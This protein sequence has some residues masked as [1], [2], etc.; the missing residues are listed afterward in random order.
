MLNVYS[1]S[2]T[3]NGSTSS[4]YG[5]VPFALVSRPRRIKNVCPIACCGFHLG[6]WAHL[7][8]YK[9]LNTAPVADSFTQH[10][11]N[12]PKTGAC[13]SY[14]L[15]QQIVCFKAICIHRSMAPRI[16]ELVIHGPVGPVSL[17]VSHVFRL[18]G[19]ISM[20]DHGHKE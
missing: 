12:N 4:Q 20:R 15:E 3:E 6:P 19:V 14:V 9:K 16:I 11:K 1:R 5:D 13:G 18:R 10:F 17:W 2:N 8:P 7:G